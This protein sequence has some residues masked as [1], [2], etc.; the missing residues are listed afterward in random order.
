MNAKIIKTNC[1]LLL[2]ILTLAVACTEDFDIQTGNSLP[3][4]TIYGTMSNLYEYQT[5]DISISSP[6]FDTLSNVG[7]SGAKVR[8]SASNGAV[9][10]LIEVDTVQG[11]YRTTEKIAGAPDL[12][13][14]LDVEMLFNGKTERY[15]ATSYMIPVVEIDS[16][17]L[18]SM[19]IM[20]RAM[21]SLLLY[22]Q[23]PSTEDYYLNR[24]KLNDS[25]ILYGRISRYAL[26][27]DMGVNGLYINGVTV[28]MFA[29][30]SEK[31][32]DNDS[33]GNNDRIYLSPDDTI[34]FSF[35]RIEKGYFDFLTQ[36]RQERNGS[37]PL[38]GGPPSN[39]VT[40]I[41]N[42]AVGYFACCAFAPEKTAAAK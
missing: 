22:A 36:C 2:L 12:E 37:H 26:M 4:V 7:V 1:T 27:N 41:S 39:I 17:T 38:F 35:S 21:Y 18:R 32:K 28:R 9:Y 29:N 19:N 42:G 30:I 24:F 33:N 34:A 14:T 13:Y 25:L 23:D 40:N 3:V 6:Y 20:G 15:R 10:D 16:I 8:I 11:R 5:V 31:E